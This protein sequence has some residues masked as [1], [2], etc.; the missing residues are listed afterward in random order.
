MLL[1]G[2]VSKSLL[3]LLLAALAFA[4]QLSAEDWLQW[5]GPGHDNS[6]AS[7]RQIPTEWSSDKNVEWRADVPGRGHSSPLIVGDLVVLGT[8]DESTETQSVV[9][10]GRKDGRLRWQTAISQGGFPPAHPKN[11]HA[12]STAASDGRLVFMSFCHHEKI[13]V[14]ALDMLGKVVWRVDAGNF[15]PQAY[16]YGYAA[17]PTIYKDSLIVTADCDTSAW[18]RA[19]RLTDGEQ[20]WVRERPLMLNWG[21]PIVASLNGRDQL[22]LSGTNMI[23]SYDPNSGA[24]LWST[25]CLTMATCGTCIWEDGLVFA[26][27]GYP[28]AET[29]AVRADGSGVVWKNKVK[30][31][32]QSMLVSGG[33]VYAFSDQGVFYCWNAKT[34]EERWKQRLRGPVSASPLLVGDLILATNEA[35]TTWVI[36]AN[37]EKYELVSQNQLGDSG[38]ASS[39]VV[40]GQL[41]MRT[42]TGE[43]AGRRES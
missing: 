30:C 3:R 21:S 13:E 2:Q 43:G 20:L 32:E 7:G 18:I 16:E 12:S 9:A 10:I 42:S 33:H 15:R 1:A 14:V 34:G 35:G 5:R 8:A 11:T 31:Y 40:D 17:S 28:D 38:F 23:A 29:V 36:R 39:V 6:A 27:G 41:F 22:L 26:S 25:P 37:P 24:P 4:G 19:F